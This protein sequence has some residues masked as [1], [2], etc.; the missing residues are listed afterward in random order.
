MA[1]AENSNIPADLLEEIVDNVAIYPSVFFDKDNPDNP[2]NN[3]EFIDYSTPVASNVIKNSNTT[4]ETLAKITERAV[5]L[6]HKELIS[7]LGRNP[8]LPAEK[9]YTIYEFGKA[10]RR[11]FGDTEVMLIGDIET[12]LALNP[13]TPPEILEELSTAQNSAIA[14]F[15]AG[16]PNTTIETLTRLA[17]QGGDETGIRLGREKAIEELAKRKNAGRS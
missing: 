9:F 16:N 12:G 11:R 5:K 6:R 4:P 8:K 14:L 1:L 13:N 3:E 17:E 2:N 10:I 15:V 7:L